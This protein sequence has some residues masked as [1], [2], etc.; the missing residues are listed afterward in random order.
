MWQP[1]V[2]LAPAIIAADFARLGE[3]LIEAEQAGADR[4]HFDVMD[5]HFVPAISIGASVVR[6]L[7]R[8][9]SLPFETH[10]MVSD[11]DYFLDQFAEAGSDTFLVH[12]EGSGRLRRTIQR[13]RSMGKRVGVAVNPATSADVLAKILPELDEVL[14]MT[15]NPGAE[16]PRFIEAILP[17]IWLVRQMMDDLRPGCDLAVEGGIDPETAY[18]AADAGANVL[19]AGPSI[20]GYDGGVCEG[21]RRLRNGA[22]GVDGRAKNASGGPFTM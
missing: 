12:A 16:K 10:L 1:V 7:R 22:L 9:T 18:V 13:I 5:G 17:K 19:I 2:K 11:P 21:M 6:S 8:I 4:I 14:I 3:Q 20:F 15:V